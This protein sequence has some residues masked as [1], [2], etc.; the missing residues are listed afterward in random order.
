[1]EANESKTIS[2]SDLKSFT[3][4]GLFGYKD[5]VLPL[6]KEVLIL[7]AE[8]G[9][10]KTNIL[11]ILYQILNPEI[12]AIKSF[13]CDSVYI[14]FSDD[15]KYEVD[16][17]NFITTGDIDYNI[18]TI[19]KMLEKQGFPKKENKKLIEAIKNAETHRQRMIIKSLIK[20]FEEREEIQKRQ[21]T[22]KIHE[23][24]S[25]LEKT[26]KLYFEILYF[27]TYRRIEEDL[28][29]LGYGN[30]ELKND[31]TTTLIQFGMEDVKK[32]FKQ[33][34][35]EIKY[36]AFELFSRVTGEMLTQFIEGLDVTTEMKESINIDILN[37][38]LSRVGE[39]NISKIEQEKIKKLV[40]SGQINDSMYDD[41][42]YFLYKL[43]NLY[44]SQSTI[45]ETIKLFVNVCNK[46]LKPNKEIIYNESTAEI[47]IKQTRNNKTIE[48][49]NL[50]SGEKQIISLF[51]KVYLEAEEDFI[52]IID[53][54]ELSISVEWQQM[55]LPD[56]MKSGKCKRLIAATH[57][58][59]IFDNELDHCA[60]ALNQF[61]TEH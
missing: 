12:D 22:L 60:Y 40:S 42:V 38:I 57:S 20:V 3:I 15:K 31:D 19:E 17:S 37:L 16:F 52:L 26:K 41:L 58:P 39:Q 2:I 7:I 14:G 59:F 36:T 9:A 6:D 33:I 53:E 45:D 35:Q 56:I 1:M 55:L 34:Q 30:I 25:N 49:N 21:K 48:L 18:I 10:G 5:I 23:N 8:N 51:S 27:P 54:P 46:Y 13:N 44:K 28:S 11:N 47:Y 32:K 61:V 29:N 50:S 4:R 24:E 43:I